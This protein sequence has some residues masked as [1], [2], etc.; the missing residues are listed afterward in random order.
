LTLAV[1]GKLVPQDP[2][3]EPASVLLQRLTQAQAVAAK[4]KAPRGQPGRTQPGTADAPPAQLDWAA[5]PT[6]AWASDAPADEYAAVAALTA[7]LK[8]W[9]QPIPQDQA[10]L[11]AVLCL[12]PRLFSAALPAAQAAQWC[13]LVG[14]AAQPLPTQVAR[15]QV[16]VATPWGNAL[17]KMRARGD[18]LETG[19]GSHGSW[20]LAPSALGVDT[21]GWP[22]GRAAWVVGHLRAQGMAALLL[23]LPPEVSEFLHARAA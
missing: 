11:A 22:D 4:P 23:A 1:Q 14:A 12:Q 15:L 17:R 19:Q 20:A 3:D 6:G 9:G 8:A 13:R 5:L 7:V 21:T 10:R 2:A 16:A 18:L